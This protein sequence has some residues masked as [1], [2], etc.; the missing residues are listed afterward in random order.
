M[1]FWAHV[2][3]TNWCLS[4]KVLTTV[5]RFSSRAID[6]I[7][8]LVH[9]IH[10]LWKLRVNDWNDWRVTSQNN[11]FM[12]AVKNSKIILISCIIWQTD[13]QSSW[14]GSSAVVLTSVSASAIPLR[15][16]SDFRIFV[17][18]RNFGSLFA[19]EWTCSTTVIHWPWTI[20]ISVDRFD[21]QFIPFLTW[22]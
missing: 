14:L 12:S 6:E 1:C 2:D 10:P 16:R 20:W 13:Y 11:G 3:G 21:L 18:Q 17:S 15:I 8:G 9:N 19:T 5:W 7:I 4:Q 22:S